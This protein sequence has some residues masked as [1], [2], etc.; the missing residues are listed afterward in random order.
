MP[1]KFNKK[2]QFNDARAYEPKIDDKFS[3]S[4]GTPMYPLPVLTVRHI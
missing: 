2:N 3:L 4:I 1:N